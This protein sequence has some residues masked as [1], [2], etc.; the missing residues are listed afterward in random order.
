MTTPQGA[1]FD[2]H[3]PTGTHDLYLK[4]IQAIPEDKRTGWRFHVVRAGESL[5]SIATTF[6]DRPSEIVSANALTQD[7]SVTTG[8]ELVVP[9]SSAIAMPHP[10]HY[11]TRV[12]DTLVTV[13]DRFNVSVENLR[14]WNQLSSSTI[15][16]NR[17]LY[18]SQPV[19][20][21]PV[22]HVRAKKSH[23]AAGPQVATKTRATSAH[24]TT[25]VKATHPAVTSKSAAK[26]SS[27]NTPT[28]KKVV[29]PKP[30]TASR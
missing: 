9:V 11:I 6:H 20:L 21:A 24:A 27:P 3:V 14:R 18:V 15:K 4:R 30:T 17:S 13:A 23:T 26:K 10:L 25:S 1:D 28:K 8:E 7:A 22:A 29:R 16:P 2:L 12:G 5:E 19:H